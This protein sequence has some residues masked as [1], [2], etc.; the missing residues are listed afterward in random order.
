MQCPV[1]AFLLSLCA[2]YDL[3]GSVRYEEKSFISLTLGVN[4]KKTC[5]SKPD[6]PDKLAIS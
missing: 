1:S 4:A 2:R 5:F 6:A 3:K